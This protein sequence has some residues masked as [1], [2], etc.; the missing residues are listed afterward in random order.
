MKDAAPGLALRPLWCD[1]KA[2]CADVEFAAPPFDYLVEAGSYR[3]QEIHS[4][5]MLTMTVTATVTSHYL[6]VP[7]AR[8]YYE[9]M[10]E[11]PVL[12]FIPGGAA[13]S[14]GFLPMG[15]RLADAFTVVRYDPRGISRSALQDP[16][17]VSVETHADDARLL[18]EAFSQEPAMVFGHSGGAVISLALVEQ[19]SPQVRTLIAHEPPLTQLLPEGDLR[20]GE[21]QEIHEI[22]LEQ[23]P[24]AA[25]TRFFQAAGMDGPPPEM[26][27]EAAAFMMEQMVRMEQNMEFF[28]AH[29]LIPITGYEPDLAKLR[30]GP[31][32]VMVGVGA[33]SEGQ[34][35][36]DT[37][38]ALA[39]GLGIE[40]VVF[41]G[42][43]VGMA[44]QPD[45]FAARLREVLGVG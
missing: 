21:A 35:T 28:L 11:G 33:E 8:L 14:N 45:A 2:P 36:W 17:T 1:I 16:H 7:G 9:V 13:D 6:D 20:R 42:D 22:Y 39:R 27:P 34:E 10:G 12:L 40:P 5:E 19:A 43:H 24:E 32:Q 25:I 29:Y 37:S 18:L 26:S 44:T 41:P 4:L 38:I 23:G 15:E 30:H 3:A 31:T